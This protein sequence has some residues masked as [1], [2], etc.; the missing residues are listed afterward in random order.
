MESCSAAL[1]QVSRVRIVRHVAGT[2]EHPSWCHLA[3]LHRCGTTAHCSMLQ[4]IKHLAT[5]LFMGNCCG[6]NVKT[7]GSSGPARWLPNLPGIYTIYSIYTG[8]AVE[9]WLVVGWLP[10]ECG[11]TPLS[12]SYH[13]TTATTLSRT[14]STA[15]IIS[16]INTPM[17]QPRCAV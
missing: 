6:E 16:L 3:F 10:V 7:P 11:A 5:S 13:N 4:I 15:S 1:L 12:P 9:P 17:A 8:G 14:Q 2:A